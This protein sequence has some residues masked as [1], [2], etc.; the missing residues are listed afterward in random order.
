MKRCSHIPAQNQAFTLVEVLV[1]IAVL[2]LMLAMILSIVQSAGIGIRYSLSKVDAF[3]SARH[4]MEALNQSL[5]RTVLQTYWDYYDANRNPRTPENAMT[6]V[7]AVY[8]R[9]SDL[10][11]KTSPA[12]GLP[13][14]DAVG[15]AIF[16]QRAEEAGLLTLPPRVVAPAAFFVTYGPN[17][18]FP[19]ISRLRNESRFRLMQWL[20]SS[21]SLIV[22]AAGKV[23]VPNWMNNLATNVFPVAEDILTMVVQVPTTNYRVADGYAWDSRVPWS[24][25]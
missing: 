9:Q 20:P 17:P 13:H 24:S 12:L 25:G 10:H 18:A 5:R 11:F 8:G 2:A 4:G 23:R 6:F 22:D 19:D 14:W 15:H 1:S 16:F 3:E 7:P 21:E